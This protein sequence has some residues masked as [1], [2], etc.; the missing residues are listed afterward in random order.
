MSKSQILF[1]DGDKYSGEVNAEGK[2]NGTG[3]YSFKNGST[4]TGGFQNNHFNGKG[5]LFDASNNLTITCTFLNSKAL[6]EGF[7]KYGDG[8]QYKG[9]L[10]DNMRSGQG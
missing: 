5:E 1:K 10:Q 2:L 8:S 3:T 6:G 9:S 4:Y 7:I